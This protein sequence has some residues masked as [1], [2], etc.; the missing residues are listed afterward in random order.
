MSQKMQQLSVRNYV[1]RAV[2]GGRKSVSIYFQVDNHPSLQLTVPMVIDY[3]F[4]P[5]QEQDPYFILN[6]FKDV[7]YR[8]TGLPLCKVAP[9]KEIAAS[10]SSVVKNFYV[11]K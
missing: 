3:T 4:N 9:Q 2:R 6:E 1:M 7:F 11:R 5:S 8:N 10:I